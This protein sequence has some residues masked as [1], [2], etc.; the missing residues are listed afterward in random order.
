MSQCAISFFADGVGDNSRI[1]MITTGIR[2]PVGVKVMG[3]KLETELDDPEA[4]IEGEV[5]V[6]PPPKVPVELLRAV[7]IRDGN[8]DHL[9]LHVWACV[10]R[11]SA[12]VGQ[13]TL[14]TLASL[15]ASFL[16][17]S[18]VLI[19]ASGVARGLP[20]RNSAQHFVASRIL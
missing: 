11:L 19:A 12:T 20:S 18:L 7:D 6:E 17:T 3:P 8:D 9:K 13:S 10:G 15:V 1:D 16:R 14:A 5:S 4:V 2:T